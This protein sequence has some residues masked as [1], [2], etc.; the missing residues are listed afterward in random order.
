MDPEI[1][2]PEPKRILLAGD[3]HGGQDGN[4]LAGPGFTPKEGNNDDQ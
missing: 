1:W 4:V 2:L 3:W